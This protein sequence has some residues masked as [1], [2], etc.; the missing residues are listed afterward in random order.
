MVLFIII[1]VVLGSSLVY[2]LY[3]LK[4]SW[5]GAGTLSTSSLPLAFHQLLGEPAKEN[6]QLSN[7]N[8]TSSSL[9]GSL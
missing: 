7:T 2:L 8:D 6:H 9:L 3:K 1:S 5:T 4:G